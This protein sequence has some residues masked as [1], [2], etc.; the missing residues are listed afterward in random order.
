VSEHLREESAALH[1]PGAAEQ[2]SLPMFIAPAR[3]SASTIQIFNCL[4][5]GRMIYNPNQFWLK[6]K[7][8]QV[9]A[10]GGS[11]NAITLIFIANA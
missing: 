9:H 1:V 4:L 10:T 5:K 7:S 11:Q 3:S 2:S 6:K 8:F